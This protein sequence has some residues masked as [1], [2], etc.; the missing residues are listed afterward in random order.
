MM[1]KEGH[2][3]GL[4]LIIADIVIVTFAFVFGFKKSIREMERRDVNE[5][6]NS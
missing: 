6:V 2:G 4:M 3:I 1:Y 5:L